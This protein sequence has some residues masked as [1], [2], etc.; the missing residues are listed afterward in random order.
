M[1]KKAAFGI[2]IIVSDCQESCFC[3]ESWYFWQCAHKF[4]SGRTKPNLKKGFGV[5]WEMASSVQAEHGKNQG[6]GLGKRRECWHRYFHRHGY[7]FSSI[8]RILAKPGDLSPRALPE[9]KRTL[10]ILP[11]SP[12]V[13]LRSWRV[14]LRKNPMPLLA[15]SKNRCPRLLPPFREAYQLAHCQQAQDSVQIPSSQ[16]R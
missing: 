8:K 10:D 3:R 16:R 12:V 15:T 14:L 1:V 6:L 9:R 13:T 5:F 7:H 4:Y 2:S 11:A